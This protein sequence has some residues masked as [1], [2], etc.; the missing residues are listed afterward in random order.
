ME[1]MGCFPGTCRE[2]SLGSCRVWVRVLCL[3][4]GLATR[5]LITQRV[6]ISGSFK[7]PLQ[8]K[9]HN[10]A[11]PYAFLLL[12]RLAPHLWLGNV[13]S[14]FILSEPSLPPC[15]HGQELSFTLKTTLKA[16]DDR[17]PR[18]APVPLLAEVFTRHSLIYRH[19]DLSYS[20]NINNSDCVLFPRL[21][22]GWDSANYQTGV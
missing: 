22:G 15:L 3:L 7:T 21:S 13:D 2:A 8:A 1:S 10:P 4:Y 16:P 14:S 9:T 11:S 20:V 5:S 18:K 6:S 17:P 12:S 19:S